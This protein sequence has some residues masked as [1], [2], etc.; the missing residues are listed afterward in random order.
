V[1]GISKTGVM[2][3]HAAAALIAL[4]SFVCFIVFPYKDGLVEKW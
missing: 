1:T 2:T 4:M 3:A